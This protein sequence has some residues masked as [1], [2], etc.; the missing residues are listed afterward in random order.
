MIR[1][2]CAGCGFTLATVRVESNPGYPPYRIIVELY[3]G[4]RF[5]GGVGALAPQEL[6]AMIER[7][8]RCGRPLS[9]SPVKVEV[10]PA[11]PQTPNSGQA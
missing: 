6:V 10:K 9:K 3:D 11:T 8:P 2:R 1:Y 4:R 7:C 5:R